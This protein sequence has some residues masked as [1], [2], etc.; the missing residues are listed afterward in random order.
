MRQ[1]GVLR[2]EDGGAFVTAI[3][4][5]WLIQLV[6]Q[7][8][9][10]PSVLPGSTAAAL[11]PTV[12]AFAFGMNFMP[13]YLDYKANSLPA[14]ITDQYYGLDS[15]LLPEHADEEQPKQPLFQD[16]NDHFE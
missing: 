14:E 4:V 12:T 2:Q 1:C 5:G 13:A 10:Q 9:I 8:L 11:P 7:I 3:W 15:T 6:V 16:S